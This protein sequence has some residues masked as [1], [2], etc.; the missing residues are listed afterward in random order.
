MK[1]FLFVFIGLFV[2]FKSWDIID[3]I[4]LFCIDEEVVVG[5]GNL[6][7]VFVY[8]VDVVFFRGI[9]VL[10]DVLELGFC[11]LIIFCVSFW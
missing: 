5:V 10:F 4:G 6:L 3:N 8:V 1:K 7:M 9:I 11:N 2:F